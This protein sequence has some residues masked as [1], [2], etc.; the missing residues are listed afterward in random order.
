MGE[1]GR[2]MLPNP[3]KTEGKEDS[4][5]VICVLC[6]SVCNV[7]MCVISIATMKYTRFKNPPYPVALADNK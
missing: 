7:Y 1:A 4:I 2:G 5:G 6:C 3:E